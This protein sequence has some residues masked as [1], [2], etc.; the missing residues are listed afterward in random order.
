MEV[1]SKPVRKIEYH[2]VTRI[3]TP[4]VHH[5]IVPIDVI[6]LLVN[7]WYMAV[8][9]PRDA[10]VEQLLY[11]NLILDYYGSSKSFVDYCRDCAKEF[12]AEEVKA[13]I[14]G[15]DKECLITFIHSTHMNSIE[16]CKNQMDYAKA[17]AKASFG[18]TVS[19]AMSVQEPVNELMP[20]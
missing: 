15:L 2:E 20:E 14:D 17:R 16:P 13:W 10:K 6:D 5:C 1:E 3:D 19:E 18:L 9:E 12:K 4:F 8:I 7:S 11:L